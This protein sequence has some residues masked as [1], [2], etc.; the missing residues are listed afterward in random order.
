MRVQKRGAAGQLIGVAI[1]LSRGRLVAREQDAEQDAVDRAEVEEVKRH[2]VRGLARAGAPCP[3]AT[4]SCL[5]RRQA[6]I[7]V[8]AVLGEDDVDHRPSLDR[9]L[10]PQRHGLRDRHDQT[11]AREPAHERV[12]VLAQQRLGGQLD[13]V[14]LLI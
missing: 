12:G 4:P 8:I 3:S 2:P 14:R 5:T 7:T 10:A 6:S 9:R 11:V 13:V 1:A